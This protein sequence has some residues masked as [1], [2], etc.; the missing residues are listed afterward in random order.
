MAFS[1]RLPRLSE[2]NP[3]TPGQRPETPEI[4]EKNDMLTLSGV[5]GHIPR[6]SGHILN[7]TA[8]FWGPESPDIYPEFSGLNSPTASFWGMGIYTPHLLPFGAA[9]SPHEIHISTAIR[10]S[11]H[12]RFAR[13]LR[14][15]VSWG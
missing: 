1:L 11:P 14:R 5:S 7:I 15:E 9:G 4:S 13:D 12:S 10:S 8:S 6:V 3:D 2:G